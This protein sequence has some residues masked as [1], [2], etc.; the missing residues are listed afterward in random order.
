[1]EIKPA[2]NP[3]DAANLPYLLMHLNDTLAAFT[4]AAEEVVLACIAH[5]FDEAA[6][7]IATTRLEER[8][9]AWYRTNHTYLNRHALLSAQVNVLNDWCMAN[10]KLSQQLLTL[11]PVTNG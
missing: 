6:H 7:K 3:V 1:M 8:V 11:Y 9:V 4:R 2:A 10:R 5:P